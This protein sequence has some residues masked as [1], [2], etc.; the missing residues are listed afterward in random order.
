[1]VLN[2]KVFC[3]I[4]VL[5]VLNKLIRVEEKE[6]FGISGIIFIEC[7]NRVY[8]I[9]F[10]FFFWLLLIESSCVRFEIYLVGEKGSEI[11]DIVLF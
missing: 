8:I 7:G 10:W 11:I 6:D 9:S 2:R 5:I 1:M 4:K 3:K